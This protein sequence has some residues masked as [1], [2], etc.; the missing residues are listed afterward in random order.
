[1]CRKK[2]VLAHKYGIALVPGVFFG[3]QGK[4]NFRMSYTIDNK[5]LKEALD[6]MVKFL[7]DL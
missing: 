2:E 1:M 7:K 4:Y 6:L 5:S 3:N